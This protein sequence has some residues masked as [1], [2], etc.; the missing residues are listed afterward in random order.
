MNR[1]I[2]GLALVCAALLPAAS[3]AAPSIAVDCDAGAVTAGDE[4]PNIHGH[5]DFL[6]IPRGTLSF[7]LMSI[8]FVGADYGGSLAP[9]RTAPVVLRKVTLAG[10]SIQLIVASRE[11]DVRFDGKLSAKG[12]F[13]CGTVTYHRGETF[14]MVAQK[15]P[16][17]YQSQPQAQRAR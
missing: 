8:G 7:G 6:M 16:S 4:A 15:R 13:M 3:E 14:P 11:G 9:A 10:K 17:T 2:A 1:I 12:D 5:W